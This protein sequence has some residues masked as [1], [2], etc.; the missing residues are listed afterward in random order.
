MESR[1]PAPKIDHL[2][3]LTDDIGIFEHAD[4]LEP[5][6]GLGYATEDAARALVVTARWLPQNETVVA[7]T[8]T[9][10]A[11]IRDSILPGAPVRNRMTPD[12]TWVGPSSADAHGRTIWGLGVAA[13]DA[14]A[15]ETVDAAVSCLD[16][17][18]VIDDPSIRPWVYTGLG[19]AALLSALPTHRVA[20]R[21][22][23]ATMHR[24]P[25]PRAGDWIWPESRLTYDNARL[26]E[27]LIGLGLALDHPAMTADGLSL[28]SWLVDIERDGDRFSFTPVGG[29]GPDS[30][31]P[32]FDQQPLE[33]TAMADACITAWKATYDVAWLDI[34]LQAVEWFTGRNDRG[35]PVYDPVTGAGHDGLTETGVSAN[36]GAESTIS[37]L[38][39]LQCGRLIESH[40]EAGSGHCSSR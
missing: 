39:A 33:A 21:L 19:A 17:M 32:A 14:A 38:W 5:R 3:R 30:A 40:L 11:F 35:I 12:R 24:L 36:A 34:G 28:L 15:G 37:A 10:L 31:R 22:A 8:A 29:R 18:E 25:R 9:Y 6:R 13:A 4:G 27:C 2:A 26:P 16:R 7:L 1:V 23:E 20:R